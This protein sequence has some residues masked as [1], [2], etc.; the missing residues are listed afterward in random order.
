MQRQNALRPRHGRL[1]MTGLFGMVLLV[2]GGAGAPTT[3]AVSDMSEGAKAGYWEDRA[4][5]IGD[6]APPLTIEEIFEP[7]SVPGAQALLDWDMVQGK[8][9]V[10]EFTASWCGPCLAIIPHMNSVFDD[11]RR[12][13]NEGSIVVIAISNELPKD[14]RKLSLNH[15]AK[16]PLVRDA[17][18][19]SFEDYWVNGI[20]FVVLVD[21]EGVIRAL[22]HP[23]EITPEAVRAVSRGEPVDLTLTNASPK[24]RSWNHYLD[25]ASSAVEPKCVVERTD[26]LA[27]VL[28]SNSKTGRIHTSGA[29][30]SVLLATSLGVPQGDIDMRIDVPDDLYFSVDVIPPDGE[31]GTS[32]DLLCQA[33]L[34]EL[35]AECIRE[36]ELSTVKLLQRIPNAPPP[37][38]GDEKESVMEAR[39]GALQLPN[40]TMPRLVQILRMFSNSP[41]VDDTGLQDIYNVQLKWDLDGGADALREALAQIGLRLVEGEKEVVKFTIRPVPHARE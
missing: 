16:V 30:P 10:L 15:G 17:D 21:P 38:P 31:I 22:T 39:P 7:Q 9:L 33:L 26:S 34:A 18:G 23:S 2:A 27:G 6:Q 1:S 5:R 20:P 19:S 28:R 8:T 3:A 14:I 41:I 40:V 35:G 11:L 13:I 37:P 4:P 36:K 25:D 24:R 32:R 29:V 12:E